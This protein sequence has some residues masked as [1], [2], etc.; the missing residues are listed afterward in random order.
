[1]SEAVAL[2]ME[3]LVVGVAEDV[4]V[5][6]TVIAAADAAASAAVLELLEQEDGCLTLVLLLTTVHLRSFLGMREVGRGEAISPSCDLG[7]AMSSFILVFG[8]IGRVE[9]PPPAPTGA[10]VCPPISGVKQGSG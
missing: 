3:L 4:I 2:L 8:D 1:M 6:V 10:R 5:A 9:P 7:K